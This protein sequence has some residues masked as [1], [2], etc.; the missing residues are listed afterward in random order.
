MERQPEHAVRGVQ[1]RV[2]DAPR[3]DADPAQLAGAREAVERLGIQVEQVP[4]HAVG[5]P[6]GPVRE[7][8]D[9]VERHA[10]AVEPTGDDAAALGAEVDRGATYSRWNTS[11]SRSKAWSGRPDSKNSAISACQRAFTS[12]ACIPRCAASKSSVSR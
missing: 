5:Q 7:A 4:A 3:A 10:P 11:S 6:H 2:V 1:Q 9:L 12:R 8:V